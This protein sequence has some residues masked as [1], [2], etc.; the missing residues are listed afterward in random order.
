VIDFRLS[1]YRAKV[2]GLMNC[3]LA[4][5]YLLATLIALAVGAQTLVPLPLAGHPKP[6]DDW[7]VISG[8][9]TDELGLAVPDAF[10]H[11]GD[12]KPPH[13]DPKCSGA[14]G[15][16]APNG[17]FRVLPGRRYVFMAGANSRPDYAPQYYGGTVVPRES[18]LVE[19]S[20]GQ[21]SV[22]NFRLTLHASATIRGFLRM[23]ASVPPG[24]PPAY[25]SLLDEKGERFNRA[26]FHPVMVIEKDGGFETRNVEPGRYLIR[27]QNSEHWAAAGTLLATREVEV[28]SEGIAGLDMQLRA[29][30]PVEFPIVANIEGGPFRPPLGILFY[31]RGVCEDEGPRNRA[32]RRDDGTFVVRL[33]PGHYTAAVGP[34]MPRQGVF[35]ALVSAHLGDHDVT[36]DGFDVDEATS[37]VLHLVIRLQSSPASAAAPVGRGEALCH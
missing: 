4:L 30:A 32:E 29:V 13:Y 34:Y 17:E 18:G 33:L 1:T 27:A 25:L 22:I 35:P 12:C 8:I 37:G 6:G 9:L 19:V 20:A 15:P 23:P 26:Y 28:G 10:L 24:S 16:S 3:K 11:A 14:F 21:E 31:Q 2:R 5:S 36:K 7:G